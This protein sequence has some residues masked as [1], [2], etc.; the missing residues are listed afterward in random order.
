MEKSG[1]SPSGPLCGVFGL[2]LVHNVLHNAVIIPLMLAFKEELCAHCLVGFGLD[3][4]YAAHDS[5]AV[6]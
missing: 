3:L 4:W 1:L 6:R 5:D 2:V